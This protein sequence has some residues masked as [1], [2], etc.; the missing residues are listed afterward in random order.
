MSMY[1]L[2]FA[3]KEVN[4]RVEKQINIRNYIGFETRSTCFRN[5]TNLVFTVLNKSETKAK[6]STIN[7]CANK[8]KSYVHLISFW[9]DSFLAYAISNN[10]Q[11]K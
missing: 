8:C 4:K 7:L 3:N 2:L 6:L 5:Q 11:E 9:V 1:R 10:K